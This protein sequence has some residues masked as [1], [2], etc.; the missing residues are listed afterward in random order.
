MVTQH[1]I[2]MRNARKMHKFHT[3]AVPSMEFAVVLYGFSTSI[4]NDTNS[5]PCCLRCTDTNQSKQ[6]PVWQL[7]N[8]WLEMHLTLQQ[9]TQCVRKKGKEREQDVAY[10]NADERNKKT[11]YT[12]LCYYCPLYLLHARAVT[13]SLGRPAIKTYNIVLGT[14]HVGTDR[15]SARQRQRPIERLWSTIH[16]TFDERK[17]ER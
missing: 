11:N 13:Y 8:S 4:C 5:W 14:Y 1:G 10:K 2:W 15:Y 17:K 7:C 12:D 16:D 3:F 6:Q 9:R